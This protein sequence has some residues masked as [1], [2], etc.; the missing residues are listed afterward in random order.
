MIPFLNGI[1]A[2]EEAFP[3]AYNTGRLKWSWSY[4][5][6]S[7]LRAGGE[8]CVRSTPLSLPYFVRLRASFVI[9][10]E[11][12]FYKFRGSQRITKGALR[13]TKGEVTD[14]EI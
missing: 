12:I 2:S 9:L 3:I 11:S 8:I 1:K 4:K 5:E 13:C 10:C 14:R 6:E 7:A